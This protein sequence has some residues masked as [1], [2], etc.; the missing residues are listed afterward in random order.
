[1]VKKE[2]KTVGEEIHTLRKRLHVNVDSVA[3]YASM[4]PST[5]EVCVKGV[6]KK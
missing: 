4:S 5:Y 2:M 6:T 3:D 1:M